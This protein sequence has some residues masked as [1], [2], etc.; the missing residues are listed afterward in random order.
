VRAKG[1]SVP[2]LAPSDNDILLRLNTLRQETDRECVLELID[3]YCAEAPRLIRAIVDAVQSGD[4]RALTATAHAL[5]GSS[6]N[7]GAHRMGTLCLSLEQRGRSGA[8]P[9]SSDDVKEITAELEH[10]KT[11]F[12]LFRQ[13]SV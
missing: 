13:E 12:Q 10:L 11:I 5:K 2:D 6:L 1:D 4:G 8:M 3:I 9:A 7:L